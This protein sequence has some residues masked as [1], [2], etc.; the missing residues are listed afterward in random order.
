MTQTEAHLPAT[1]R[2]AAARK[3]LLNPVNLIPFPALAVL[4][5][6]RHY[7]LIANQPLWLLLGS[8]VFTQVST[9][10]IAVTFPPGTPNARPR[11]LLSAQIVLT[12]LCVYVNGWGALL[13]VGFVFAAASAIHSDGARYALWAMGCTVLD[14]HRRRVRDRGGMGED[15]GVRTRRSRPRVARGGGHLRGHLD[16]RAQPT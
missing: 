5:L 14:R 6:A 13:A 12:G 9:T 3:A 10:S 2:H 1:S 16:P 11:L 8:M 4:A 7:H 15:D